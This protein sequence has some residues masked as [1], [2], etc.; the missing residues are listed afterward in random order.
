MR[1]KNGQII[2][3]GSATIIDLNFAF[4]RQLQK[5]LKPSMLTCQIKELET[6]VVV[7]VSVVSLFLLLFLLCCALPWPPLPCPVSSFVVLYGCRV[8]CLSCLFAQAANFQDFTDS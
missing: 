6:I 5:R 2:V 7:S 3:Y 1:G 8:C 4:V